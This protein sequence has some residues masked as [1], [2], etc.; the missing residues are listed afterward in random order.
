MIT[1]SGGINL[2]KA[3]TI[4]FN[5]FYTFLYSVEEGFFKNNV[6]AFVLVRIALKCH[7]IYIDKSL[8]RIV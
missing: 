4:F 6:S 5:A 2:K 8:L 7:M 1:L 3:S